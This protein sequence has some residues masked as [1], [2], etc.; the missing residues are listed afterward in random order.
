M[1]DTYKCNDCGA[2]TYE[3]KEV[4]TSYEHYYGA[5]VPTYTPFTYHTC[6]SCGSEDISIIKVDEEEDDEL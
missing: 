5:P 2:I 4:N 3:P 6:P 1:G